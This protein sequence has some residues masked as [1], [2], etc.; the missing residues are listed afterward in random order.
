M[1]TTT[2]AT[3]LREPKHDLVAL[4]HTEEDDADDAPRGILVI[5]SDV[6]D[7]CPG[8]RAARAPR[9]EEPMQ[10]LYVLRSIT[11]CVAGRQPGTLVLRGPSRP[12]QLVRSVFSGL[13]LPEG[14]V[15]LTEVEGQ[16]SCADDDCAP[17]D[18]RVEIGL[19]G[20]SAVATSL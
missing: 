5:G 18:L 14:Q 17:E 15:E 16:R 20:S 6:V 4:V 7:A 8:V 10:W 3:A 2:S 13:G 1:A 9:G 19:G 12:Q 11:A